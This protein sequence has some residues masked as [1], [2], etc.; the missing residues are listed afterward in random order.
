MYGELRRAE[1]TGG[2]LGVP[3]FVTAVEKLLGRKI[4]RHRPQPK[5]RSPAS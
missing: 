2:P 5:S 3:E 4:A 1:A